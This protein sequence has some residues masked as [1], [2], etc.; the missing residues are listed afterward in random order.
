MIDPNTQQQAVQE[1][2]VLVQVLRGEIVA[3]SDDGLMFS[4]IGGDQKTQV[5]VFVPLQNVR[6]VTFCMEH[7]SQEEKKTDVSRIIAPN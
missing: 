4:G 7:V 2:P 5:L 3:L 6:A 1:Q